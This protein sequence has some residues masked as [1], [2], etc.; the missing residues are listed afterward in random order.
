MFGEQLSVWA[1]CESPSSGLTQKLERQD[2]CQFT[3]DVHKVGLNKGKQPKSE[4][5]CEDCSLGNE[6]FISFKQSF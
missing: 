5:I 6:K 1:D 4:S 3:R 2:T